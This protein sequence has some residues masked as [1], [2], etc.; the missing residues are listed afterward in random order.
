MSEPVDNK[1]HYGEFSA[2]FMSLD[3]YLPKFTHYG[4]MNHLDPLFH[5]THYQ[6]AIL[7]AMSHL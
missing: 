6:S 2:D 1:A 3:I 4:T 7:L 5:D